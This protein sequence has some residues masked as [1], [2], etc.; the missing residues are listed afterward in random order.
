MQSSYGPASLSSIEDIAA[1]DGL[2]NGT[3]F[4]TDTTGATIYWKKERPLKDSFEKI[5][6][7]TTAVIE[8]L[9]SYGSSKAVIGTSCCTY[10]ADANEIDVEHS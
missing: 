9:H 6:D 2:P 5:D 8:L 10:I 3:K 4:Y 1:V 7:S